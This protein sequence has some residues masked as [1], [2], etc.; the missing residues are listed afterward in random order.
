VS[1]TLR[2]RASS[3]SR[4]AITERAALCY[5][6]LAGGLNVVV[7]LVQGRAILVTDYANADA[8]S[9]LVLPKLIGGAPSGTV[10]NLGDHAWYESWLFMRATAGLPGYRQLWEIAPFVLVFLGVAILAWCVFTVF[11]R[12]AAA[13]TTVV[14]VSDGYSS[15]SFLFG[16]A[17]DGVVLHAAL[18]CAVLLI[19]WRQLSARSLTLRRAVL[20][21]AVTAALTAASATDAL[22][23]IGVIVPFM[24]A[25]VAYWYL[26]R[27]RAGA[28]TALFAVATGGVAI[29]GGA[30]ITQIMI[31]EHVIAAAFPLTFVPAA[32]L[33]NAFQ[34]SI[35]AFT[36]IGDGGFYGA[37]ANQ[38][39]WLMFAAA[40]LCLLGL[41]AVAWASWRA[42]RP[43]LTSDGPADAPDDP[44][45]GARALFVGFWMLGLVI[46]FGAFSLTSLGATGAP[47][48]LI[49]AWFSVAAL[50]GLLAASRLHRG[51]VIAGVLAFSLITA[52]ELITDGEPTF[53]PTATVPSYLIADEIDRYVTSEHASLGFAGYWEAAPL[54]LETRFRLTVA[55]IGVCGAFFCPFTISSLS[56]WYV[57]H[58]R[59]RS[60]LLTT[61]VQPLDEIAGPAFNL[62]RAL[63]F[64]TFGPF[65]VYVYP[66]D[67]AKA[68]APAPP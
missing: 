36:L 4:L 50:L 54:S 9:S 33:L 26:T 57:P 29:V 43:F 56:S 24:L 25:P 66:Y 27:T 6:T 7:F 5:L 68:F 52:N 15:R 46:A 51:L 62:G 53:G 47:R 48:Y 23:T 10:V 60:F 16:P 22:E 41:A 37:N 40:T 42:L 38:A 61:T 21:G 20:L 2:K 49:V 65:T 35:A 13:L 11:G 3:L 63:N 1:A 67:I 8:A 30:V 55:P 18:L 59:T 64:E 28:L 32:G 17:R 44:S 31:S 19:F 14:L 39:G 34:T 45:E 58:P 12:L